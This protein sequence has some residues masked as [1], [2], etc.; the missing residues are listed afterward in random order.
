MEIKKI[1]V[2]VTGHLEDTRVLDLAAV[3][4]RALYAHVEVLHVTADIGEVLLYATGHEPSGVLT[5]HLQSFES[6]A[7][8]V[9]ET[10]RAQF[11]AWAQRERLEIEVEE[12]PRSWDATCCWRSCSGSPISSIA[13]LGRFCDL[14]VVARPDTE[15]GEPTS[16]IEAA[17]F[18]TGRPLLLAPPECPSHLGELGLIAWNGSPEALRAIT[19]SLP[20][21]GRLQ[22][23]IL[24]SIGRPRGETDETERELL[25]YLGC[26]GINAERLVV[27]PDERTAGERLLDE[28]HRLGANLLIMG[29]YAHSRLRES[30]LGGATH[31]VIRSAR[32][33]VL[34]MH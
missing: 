14:V 21:L 3:I 8:R 20:I 26:H 24:L 7:R 33:P 9:G 5:E 2:P 6:D 28:A 17:L 13:R 27:E 25:D 12:T 15:A 19:A 31:H 30:L 11:E 18:G 1:L 10:A 23:V 29:A 32:I 34:L 22:R 4:G 16:L